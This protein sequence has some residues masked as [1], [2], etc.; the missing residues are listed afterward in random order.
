MVLQHRVLLNPRAGETWNARIFA[1]QH[2]D[3]RQNCYI[4]VFCTVIFAIACR[5]GAYNNI[6]LEK[7]NLSI[8]R[9]KKIFS[10][11]NRVSRTLPRERGSLLTT[12]LYQPANGFWVN[13]RSQRKPRAAQ[14]WAQPRCGGCSRASCKG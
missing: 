9:L 3:F 1:V 2:P 12:S 14:H 13:L 4:C 10:K 11:G 6:S 8:S 5:S 7:Q